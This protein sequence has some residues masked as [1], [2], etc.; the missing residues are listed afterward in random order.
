MQ[1][2]AI[3]ETCLYVDD[4]TTAEQFYSEILGL[5][6]LSYIKGRHVFFQCGQQVFLLF[7]PTETINSTGSVPTHGAQGA[8]HV[9]FAIAEAELNQWRDHLTA[10]SI[11][12]EADIT[13]PNGG[14]S[15]YFRD[16]AGNCLE[17]ATPKVWNISETEMFD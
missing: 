5:K 11:P 10:H 4:L 1:T 7:N 14:R 8:G 2:K 6:R 9:A 12:I 17:V 16:P 3:L 15:L 13:W